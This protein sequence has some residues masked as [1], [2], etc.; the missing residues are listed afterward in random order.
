MQPSSTPG[1]ISTDITTIEHGRTHERGHVIECGG[2][3]H[4]RQ[5][6]GAL[7]VGGERAV[8]EGR[9]TRRHHR[10]QLHEE[11]TDAGQDIVV[12]GHHRRLV[13]DLTLTCRHRTVPLDCDNAFFYDLQVT[14]SEIT[15]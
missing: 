8:V 10:V 7:R 12:D 6:F 2:F 3:V 13:T 11:Y 9:A 4:A 14:R 1:R 15:G 5:V